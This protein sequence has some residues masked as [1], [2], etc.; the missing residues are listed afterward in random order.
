[1]IR[2]IDPLISLPATDPAR[3]HAFYTRVLGLTAIVSEEKEGFY[4]YSGGGETMI[5]VHRHEGTIPPPEQQGVWVWLDV[6]EIAAARSRMEPL[7]VRFLG[8]PSVLGPGMQQSFVDSEGNVLRLFELVREVR[9]SVEIA[10]APADAF[11]ALTTADSVSQWFSAIQ[12]VRLDPRLGGEFAFTDPLF[13]EVLGRIT[14]FEPPRRVAFQFNGNWPEELSYDVTPTAKGCRVD[15]L[16]RGFDPIKDRDFGI[17]GLIEHLD[18]ALVLFEA[19]MKAG[20]AALGAVNAA[21]SI[22]AK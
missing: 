15:V 9:R 11:A 12:Q 2:R 17:P 1:M 20:G 22:R 14:E 21:R 4:I 13:G 5:G 19:L 7:G 18:Q 16:Q 8:K 10:C 3:A 6:D